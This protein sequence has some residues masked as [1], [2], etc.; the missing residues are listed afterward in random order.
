MAEGEHLL[1]NVTNVVVTVS[2]L[3]TLGRNSLSLWDTGRY[4]ES[5][6]ADGFERLDDAHGGWGGSKVCE[7][8]M[9]AGA[10]NHLSEEALFFD[11]SQMP[12]EYPDEVQV[13][14]LGEEDRLWRIYSIE[15]GLWIGWTPQ[16]G[17]PIER[18]SL[19]E[20]KVRY[21]DIPR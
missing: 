10:F 14:I 17:I 3:D 4:M 9:F 6:G 16:P 11:L 13:M 1:S 12:F 21:P 20:I 19:E 8:T 2:I 5:G 15:H 7:A 18:L